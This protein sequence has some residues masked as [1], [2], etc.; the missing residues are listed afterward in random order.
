[1][2]HLTATQSN[3]STL[4]RSLRPEMNLG[5]C[6]VRRNKSTLSLIQTVEFHI[7]LKLL[8]TRGGL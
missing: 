8:D 6:E 5:D 2:S 1:M 3:D 7:R 4:Q